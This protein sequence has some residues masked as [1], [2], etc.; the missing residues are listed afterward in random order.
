MVPHCVHK[1]LGCADPVIQLCMPD[2]VYKL[3]ICL[4]PHLNNHWMLLLGII[5][6]LAGQD[7]T[8]CQ[9]TYSI[10]TCVLRCF[11]KI[12]L[13]HSYRSQTRFHFKTISCSVFLCCVVMDS[14][15]HT[16]HPSEGPRCM[17]VWQTQQG[18]HYHMVLIAHSLPSSR[19]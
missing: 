14:I 4:Q 2:S 1:P 9:A 8:A 18:P 7:C 15:A 13:G 3:L 16:V 17:K 5:A 12:S 10:S 6:C 11:S 19:P